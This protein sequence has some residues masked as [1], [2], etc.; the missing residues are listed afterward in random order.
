MLCN[1]SI[2]YFNR[3]NTLWA[4]HKYSVRCEFP[5]INIYGKIKSENEKRQLKT[6]VSFNSKPLLGPTNRHRKPLIIGA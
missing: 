4:L 3:K 2:T 6:I 5:T 1:L